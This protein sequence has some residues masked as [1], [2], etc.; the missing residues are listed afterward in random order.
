MSA[1]R[2]STI[3]IGR[4]WPSLRVL[5]P[6]N[7]SPTIGRHKNPPLSG[8]STQPTTSRATT[9]LVLIPKPPES[10][11]VHSYLAQHAYDNYPRFPRAG[12]TNRAPRTYLHRRRLG[13]SRP[14]QRKGGHHNQQCHVHSLCKDPL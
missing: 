6:P 5:P 11:I 1:S 2:P 9:F 8:Q 7:P 4:Q 10:S 13:R 14:Q 3:V 12:Q